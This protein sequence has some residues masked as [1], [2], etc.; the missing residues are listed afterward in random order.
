[1]LVTGAS[2]GL[3]QAVL[4]RLPD[5]ALGVS[6]ST[7]GQRLVRADSV[8]AIEQAIGAR[9]ISAIIHCAWP[10]PDNESLTELTDVRAATEFNLASPVREMIELAQLLRRRGTPNSTLMLIGS[11]FAEPGRHNYRMPFYSLTKS[12]VPHLARI[13]ATELAMYSRRC[14]AVV[15][16][17]IEGG[18]NKRLSAAGRAAHRDRS[19]FGRIA[20]TDDAAA[21]LLW[22]LQNDSFLASGSTLSL[23]GAALP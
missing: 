17:V 4:A 5:T 7:S 6:R 13:F 19:P 18:M 14:I 21:Q 8:A 11:A 15:F 3:A 12:I 22:V 20:S 9:K 23:T 10:F 2:G 16:D 1:V